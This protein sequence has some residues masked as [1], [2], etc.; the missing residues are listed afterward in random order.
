MKL[1]K[2][3]TQRR[4]LAD[5]VYDQIIDAINDG[6]IGESDRLVQEKLAA[7]LQISRTPVREALLRLEQNGIL[8]TSR[9]GGFV[10]HKMT[11]QEVK[12]L[13]QTRAA[14]E[15]QAARNLAVENDA[16]K[17]QKIKK[18]ILREENISTP[19]TEAYYNAN[20]SIHRSFI[21]LTGNPYLLDIF[22]NIWNRGTSFRL[23]AAIEKLDLS[24]H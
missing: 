9:G 2:I 8:R 3:D 5:H 6:G 23:F 16:K 20:R 18:I 13:Y 19:S 7:E 17:I 10:I 4:R 22:D 11:D 24:S 15:G 12:Y 14:I 21:E 1:K